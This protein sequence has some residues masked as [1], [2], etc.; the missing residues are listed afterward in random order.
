[1][2]RRRGLTL[3]YGDYELALIEM[4]QCRL[5]TALREAG[6]VGNGLMAGADALLSRAIGLRPQMHVDDEGR[7]RLVVAGQIAE[8]RLEDVAVEADRSGSYGNENYSFNSYR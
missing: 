8:E 7:W 1:M 5:H 2:L 6:I 4:A 3:P